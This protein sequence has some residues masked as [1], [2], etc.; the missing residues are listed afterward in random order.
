MYSTG[1]R[2]APSTSYKRAAAGLCKPATAHANVTL[3]LFKPFLRARV[4]LLAPPRDEPQPGQAQR[5]QDQRARLGDGLGF[6]RV[7][8][9][10]VDE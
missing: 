10:G 8:L 3:Q 7:Q 1:A 4:S 5:G 2:L 6:Y 9:N